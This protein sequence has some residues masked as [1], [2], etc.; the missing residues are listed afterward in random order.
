M[1]VSKLKGIPTHHNMI[2][3]D[4]IWEKLLEF[5]VLVVGYPKSLEDH[6][7]KVVD[8]LIIHIYLVCKILGVGVGFE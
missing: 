8:I 4:S 2:S 3:L 6:D 5:K 1:R 7:V